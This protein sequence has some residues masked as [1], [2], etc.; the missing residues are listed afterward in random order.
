MAVGQLLLP[1]AGLPS[2][3]QPDAPR[4]CPAQRAGALSLPPS[5]TMAGQSGEVVII[6]RNFQLLGELEK[7]EKGGGDMSC[8]LGLVESDDIFLTNWQCTILG[9]MNTPV[10][11]RIVSLVMQAGPKYPDVPPDVKFQSKVNFPFV[12]RR[13]R[14]QPPCA[15][16]PLRPPASRGL[17]VRWDGEGEAAN[18]VG[19]R[20]APERPRVLACR[21]RMAPWIRRSCPRSPVGSIYLAPSGPSS[22]SWLRSRRRSASRSTGSCSSRPRAPTFSVRRLLSCRA[23]RSSVLVRCGRR[24][25]LVINTA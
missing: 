21:V 14:R 18:T 11:S 13:G 4:R 17:R 22:W 24:R 15:E 7:A 9:P 1:S 10:D 2:R 16:Q 8:S 25:D 23:R 6:P 19:T 3:F 5:A 12:V 20:A